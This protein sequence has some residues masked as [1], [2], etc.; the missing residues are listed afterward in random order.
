A[1]IRWFPDGLDT[2]I[3]AGAEELSPEIQQQISLARIVLRD[4][5]VLIMDEATSEAGSDNARMLETAA[6]RIAR[7]RTSLVVAHRLDQAVVADRIIVMEEGEIVE[8]GTHAELVARGGRYA[9]L[10]ERWSE[11]ADSQQG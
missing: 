11:G 8:D 4:P 2:P 7:G 10:F 3:G 1:Y 5:P 9:R 6:T